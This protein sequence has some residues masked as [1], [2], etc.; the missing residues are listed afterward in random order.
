MSEQPKVNMKDTKATILDAYHQLLDKLNEKGQTAMNADQIK[1]N[2]KKSEAVDVADTSLNSNQ[3]ENLIGM[4]SSFNEAVK[5]ELDKYSKIKE[6]INAKNEELAELFEIEKTAFSLAALV[7]SHQLLKE[8][9]EVEMA[10]RKEELQ[11]ELNELRDLIEKVK[12]EENERRKREQEEY[13]YNKQRRTLKDT[14]SLNDTLASQKKVVQQQLG[15]E[16]ERL[17]IREK[18][19]KEREAELTAREQEIE[20]MKAKIESIPQLLTDEV[21]RKVGKAEGMLTSKHE[22]EKKFMEAAAQSAASVS[23]AKIT[24]MSKTIETL[25]STIV[26][27]QEKLDAAYKEIKEMAVKTVEGAGNSQMFNEMKS[28]LRGNEKTG[29]K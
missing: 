3:I 12:A 7:D 6:A 27:Q 28:L 10:A 11:K 20:E 15:E 29:T 14:D 22:T 13:E 18:D 5:A 25:K 17:T 8:N 21:K 24:E 19:V 23:E 26:E 16:H 4:I 9:M 2:K 1:M